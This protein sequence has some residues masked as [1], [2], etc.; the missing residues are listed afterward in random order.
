MWPRYRNFL[1]FM[2][3]KTSPF[4]T[5][6][7]CLYL[8]HGVRVTSQKLPAFYFVTVH[9]IIWNRQ[10]THSSN[11]V[12]PLCSLLVLNFWKDYPLCWSNPGFSNTRLH[13]LPLTHWSFV[14][15][16]QRVYLC[17]HSTSLWSVIR[18]HVRIEF[19]PITLFYIY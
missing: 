9:T 17:T 2:V 5:S 14:M 19:F 12:L 1:A 8:W 11:I 4:I 6:R 10:R 3:I 16:L 13:F 15:A 18:W 7:Q